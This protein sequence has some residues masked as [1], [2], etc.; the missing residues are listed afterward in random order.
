MG[1]HRF[2]S[3]VKYIGSYLRTRILIL[4]CLPAARVWEGGEGRGGTWVSTRG[5]TEGADLP[6]LP[7]TRT[8][9]PSAACL[10]HKV[11]AGCL[12]LVEYSSTGTY[13]LETSLCGIPGIPDGGTDA[14]VDIFP[15]RQGSLC[16]ALLPSSRL[17]IIRLIEST[18]FSGC[19]TS[20]YDNY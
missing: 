5:T 14:A 19:S 18:C 15:Q 1:T 16:R 3:C 4:F 17:S 10:G 12:S 13:K 20:T 8:H 7:V 6:V 9:C 11:T 2:Y